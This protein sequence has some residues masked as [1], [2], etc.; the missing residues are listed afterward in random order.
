MLDK[1][2]VTRMK[3]QFFDLFINPEME[4]RKEKGEKI[5]PLNKILILLSTEKNQSNKVLFNAEFEAHIELK[6][7]RAVEKGE[8]IK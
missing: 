1:E 3:N 4:R 2:G 7:N 8:L 5:E 6:V